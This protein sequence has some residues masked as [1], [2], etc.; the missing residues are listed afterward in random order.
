MHLKLVG[1]SCPGQEAL[2]AG[3]DRVEQNDGQ[4]DFSSHDKTFP[5][6][7]EEGFPVKD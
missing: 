2:N 4:A 5:K 1:P 3:L 7:L 6:E